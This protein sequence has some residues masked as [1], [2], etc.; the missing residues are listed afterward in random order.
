MLAYAALLLALLTTGIAII[1]YCKIYISAST[2]PAPA[3]EKTAILFYTTAACAIFFAA[4]YLL[5]VLLSDNFRY[6]YVF[7]YSARSQAMTYKISAFW[8]GQEGSF[9]LWAV[10][11]AIFGLLLTRQKAPAAMIAYCALQFLLLVALAVKSPFRPA[12]GLEADGLGLNP[13]LQD[14]WMVIHPPIVFL[15]YAALAVPFAW[16]IH[17]LL[18]GRHKEMVARSLAWRLAA[19]AGWGAGIFIGS[20]WAYKGLGGGGNWAWDPVENASLVPWLLTGTLLHLLLLARVYDTAIKYAYLAAIVNFVLVLYGTYLTRS[21]VLNNFSVHAFQDHGIGDLL[22]NVV[23]ITAAGGLTVLVWRWSKLPDGQLYLQI[24]SREFCLCVAAI[25]L[26]AISLIVFI[27]MTTPLVTTLFGKPTSVGL[28]FYNTASLPLV[29]AMAVVLAGGTLL[30]WGENS[31]QYLLR[32]YRWLLVMALAV[33]IPAFTLGIRNPFALITASAALAAIGSTVIALQARTLSW[34]AGV[35]HIGLAMTLTG[36]VFSSLTAQSVMIDFELGQRQALFG[37]GITYLGK[38]TDI[39]KNAFYHEFKLDDPANALLLPYTKLDA[40][41]DPIVH[42]PGIYRGLTADIYLTPI[43]QSETLP[44]LQLHKGETLTAEDLDIRF[45]RFTMNSGVNGEIRA[46]AILQVTKD[47]S[48]QEVRPELVSQ[49]GQRQLLR[50]P[51]VAFNSCE[52]T[53]ISLNS[54]DGVV[55]ITLRNLA[56]KSEPETLVAEISRK[57]LMNLVW[58]G[59][60]LVTLGTVWATV[61]RSRHASQ[62]RPS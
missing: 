3:A 20:S 32:R 23:W 46:A 40:A 18:T 7:S 21:G 16:A 62:Q 35:T 30:R 11:H 50:V 14:P 58:L 15:G 9:L 52:I 27:G 17:G 38:K 48:V 39:G 60:F 24:K 10:F 41:G 45:I 53:L 59:T 19:G 2:K 13:L 29:A 22:G 31:G 55:G 37:Q 5:Y 6:E 4:G 25:L 54:K 28:Y 49:S 1:L 51:V 43:L 44:E 57:P 34:Q 33:T 36:I 26:A 12:S 56:L 61:A 47:G 42:E 8:A